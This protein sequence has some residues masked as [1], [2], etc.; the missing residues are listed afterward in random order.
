M[1]CCYIDSN[2]ASLTIRWPPMQMILYITTSFDQRVVALEGDRVEV[3]GGV[4]YVNGQP[5]RPFPRISSTRKSLHRRARNIEQNIDESRNSGQA[6]YSLGATVVP[7][8]HILVLGDNRDASFDSHV[9]G[10]LP[11]RNVVGHVKARYWPI[12][13]VAWFWRDTLFRLQ[14]SSARGILQN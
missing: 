9:W 2:C 3:Q 6:S 13:R 10:P 7:Q 14:P 8:D 11:V 4:V 1:Y 12:N 5:S